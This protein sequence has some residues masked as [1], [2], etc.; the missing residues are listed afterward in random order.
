MGY[1][2]LGG[3]FTVFLA[4]A[5]VEKAMNW[6]ANTPFNVLFGYGVLAAAFIF[7]L[8]EIASPRP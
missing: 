3:L 2:F 7:L 6:V 5:A 1:Q 8:K 4:I